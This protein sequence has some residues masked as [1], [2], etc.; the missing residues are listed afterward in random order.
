[1]CIC[2]PYLWTLQQIEPSSAHTSALAWIQGLVAETYPRTVRLR[3]GREIPGPKQVMS[4]YVIIPVSWSTLAI[5]AGAVVSHAWSSVPCPVE[6]CKALVR[7][8]EVSSLK[9]WC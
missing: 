7:F 4:V 3:H 8:V 1:M 2:E 6:G 5:H 9:V